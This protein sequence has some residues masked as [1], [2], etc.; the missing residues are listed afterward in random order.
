VLG[1]LPLH[2]TYVRPFV[3]N[4]HPRSHPAQGIGIVVLRPAL[5]PTTVVVMRKWSAPQALAL[6]AQHRITALAL[7][8]DAIL[9]VVAA[10]RAQRNPTDL[11]SITAVGSGAAYLSEEVRK[12]LVKIVP[13]STF[14]SQG[15]Y[16]LLS[17]TCPDA[18]RRGAGYGMSEAVRRM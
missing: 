14:V 9:Q 18:H 16:W 1:F 7:V 2:H 5:A 10:H 6:V 12:E 15:T 17:T 8:P 13:Q 4:A 3:T 11:S